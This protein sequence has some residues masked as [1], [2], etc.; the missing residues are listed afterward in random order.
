M[1]FEWDANKALINLAKHRVSFKEATEVFE[2]PDALE[3]YDFLHSAKETRFSM[4]GFSSRRLLFV[5][6][7]ERPT[8]TVRLI[9][10]RKANQRERK[11]YERRIN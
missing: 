1:R 9:S 5:V 7:S 11:L 2:D 10:A 8:D 4:I 3:D 6:Y